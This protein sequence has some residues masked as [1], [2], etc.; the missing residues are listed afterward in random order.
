[1]HLE[2]DS[3][4]CCRAQYSSCFSLVDHAL[5]I[6][7]QASPTS[8]SRAIECAP[9][10]RMIKLALLGHR[11]DHRTPSGRRCASLDL[12]HASRITVQ[13]CVDNASD[14]VTVAGTL[15]YELH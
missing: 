15:V 6:Q 11:L 12:L 10:L 1:M 4:K 14:E 2:V 3:H 8:H 5:R 7:T 9:P 13:M